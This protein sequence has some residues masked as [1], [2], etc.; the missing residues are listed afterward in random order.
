M[1]R[2]TYSERDDWVTEYAAGP[3]AFAAEG[4]HDVRPF[5]SRVSGPP[6]MDEMD[7]LLLWRWPGNGF[8]LSRGVLK[9]EALR[10]GAPKPFMVGCGEAEGGGM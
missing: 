10:D 3:L 8:G 9:A 7:M 2:G 5:V 6:I 1:S 4:P